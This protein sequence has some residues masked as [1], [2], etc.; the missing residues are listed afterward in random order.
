LGKKIAIS[1]LAALVLTAVTYIAV[2][3]HLYSFWD[4][5]RNQGI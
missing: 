5:V 4:A 1:T 2:S 3:S